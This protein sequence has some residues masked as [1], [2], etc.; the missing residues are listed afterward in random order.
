MYVA[1]VSAKCH[2]LDSM[3]NISMSFNDKIRN[4]YIYHSIGGEENGKQIKQ[5]TSW[6]ITNIIIVSISFVTLCELPQNKTNKSHTQTKPQRWILIKFERTW[7]FVTEYT[8]VGKLGYTAR[9]V[10]NASASPHHINII[11]I[12]WSENLVFQ[13]HIGNEPK[14]KIK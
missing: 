5:T 4:T 12:I 10:N 9:T 8:C 1:C 3:I 13:S 2:L 6:T 7:L 14:N 11:N